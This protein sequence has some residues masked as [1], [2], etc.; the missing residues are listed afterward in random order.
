MRKLRHIGADAP[1]PQGGFYVFP[2]FESFRRKLLKADIRTSVAFCERLLEETG[3]AILPGASF[4]RPP[5]EFTA[6]IAFVDF[7]G[8]RALVGAE[9][10]PPAQE[11]PDDFVS[12]YCGSVADA[13]DRMCDW[14]VGL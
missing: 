4:G 9:A 8:S 12:T 7:D 5:E 1:A 10:V 11:L 3:V 2:S 13:M 6:R 14:I